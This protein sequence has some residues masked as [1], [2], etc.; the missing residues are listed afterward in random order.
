MKALIVDD[1]ARVRKA[2]RLLVDWDKH[3]IKEIEEVSGGFDAIELIRR[4]RPAI[5]IMDMMM[6]AG[7]GVDL[8]TWVKEFA[9]S[10]KFIVV[11]GRDDFDFVRQ[12]VRHGGIDYLLKPIEPEAINAAVSKAAAEWLQEEQER[13]RQQ[14]QSWKLNELKPVY[15]DQLLTGLID[16]P[17]AA[18]NNLRR[19]CEEGV[20][21]EHAHDVRLALLQIDI[22]DEQLHKRFGSDSNLLHYFIMNV[23]NEFLLPLKRG[24]A[25]RYKGRGAG[26]EIIIA[27]WQ[28][29]DKLPAILHSINEG[30]FVTLQRRMHF[31]LSREGAFPDRMQSLYEEAH[32]AL[33]HRDSL[34]MNIYIHTTQPLRTG[35]RFVLADWEED[36][37][38][39][40]FSGQEELLAAA[41]DKWL[42][43]ARQA[44]SITPQMLDEYASDA[45]L[46][47]ARLLRETIG[48][49]AA[50]EAVHSLSEGA[51]A[52][53][54][55]YSNASFFSLMDWRD[56]SYQLL[57]RLSQLVAERQV[58]EKA[59]MSDIASYIEQYYQSELSLQ[60]IA[61]RFFVSREYVSRKFK[62]EYGIN[63]SDYITNFRIEKAKLL[64]LNPNLR[65][66]KI[67][68]M[69]GFHDEKYFSKVFKKQEGKSPK[70]FR[71]ELKV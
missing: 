42:E 43:A 55:P 33:W 45:S 20:V 50:E 35:K 12:T 46:F 54:A 4:D 68:E 17:R 18:R 63:I 25:F 14:Q 16:E 53:K 5:V 62:L 3:G 60:D 19:L 51:G 26:T 15:G 44:G 41:S 56:W 24:V 34:N 49:Q 30:L 21:P 9:S 38:L 7:S 23:C 36:W 1:E 13:N 31:G 22:S 37:R 71:M 57:R 32:T 58:Q 29:W 65:V 69:V 59:T 27:L 52:L 67:A 28:D 6:P 47:S 11:S 8:M 39:A 61:A 10:V 66:A 48:G 2:V 40:V 70:T 64:M